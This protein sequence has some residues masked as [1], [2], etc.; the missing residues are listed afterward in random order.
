[1][2]PQFQIGGRSC[3][4][5]DSFH[6]KNIVEE[7]PLFF[8]ERRLAPRDLYFGENALAWVCDHHQRPI[9][10]L[11]R[12][13]LRIATSLNP[14]QEEIKG[15]VQAPDFAPDRFSLLSLSYRAF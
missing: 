9:L 14:W 4:I 13:L 2:L 7:Q 5:T 3:R 15:E 12:N 6:W 11:H 10:T 8:Q 1:M